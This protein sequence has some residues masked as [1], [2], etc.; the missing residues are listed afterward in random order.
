MPIK[1][2]KKKKEAQNRAEANRSYRTR[3]FA[4]VVYPD[5]APPNWLDILDELHV[6]CLI[7]PIHDKDIDPDGNI[8]K[9]HYHVLICFDGVKDFESQVKPI[10]DSIGGVGR[11]TVNSIR[12]YARY[13]CHLDN[14]D[15]F[16]YNPEE[17][18]QLG[19]ADY[20]SITQLPTDDIK[21]LMDIVDYIQKNEILSFAEFIDV[22]KIYHADWFSLII[23][24]KGW[25]VKEFIKSYA[26]EKENSYVRAFDR[27]KDS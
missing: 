17:V 24:S 23:N 16:Q 18:K 4:T 26:W 10:F 13:L 5:S 19:G 27:N 8:K 25:I 22:S 2:K 21:T 6:S 14:P 12:G 11:E 20:Y 1:N 15:K 3:N 9:S 7:S